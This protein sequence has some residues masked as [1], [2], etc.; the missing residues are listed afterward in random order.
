MA[1]YGTSFVAFSVL[2]FK[3]NGKL[4]FQLKEK[5]EMKKT[6]KSRSWFLRQ[7][8]KKK[9]AKKRKRRKRKRNELIKNIE[10]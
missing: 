3:K 8:R 4:K 2:A 10:L 7:R 1:G 6:E 5:K 9:R